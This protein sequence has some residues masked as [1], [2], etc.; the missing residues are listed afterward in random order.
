MGICLSNQQTQDTRIAQPSPAGAILPPEKAPTNL[1]DAP[2]QQQPPQHVNDSQQPIDSHSKLDPVFTRVPDAPEPGEWQGET[3]DVYEEDPLDLKPGQMFTDQ[4]RVLAL[5]GHGDIGS[6][7]EVESVT[8]DNV[9]CTIKM[10]RFWGREHL[11]EG[12]KAIQS[13]VS[14]L[15]HDNVLSVYDVMEN[16][17]HSTLVTIAA[18]ASRGNLFKY[19]GTLN[20][21]PEL[22]RKIALDIASGLRVLHSYGIYHGSL[23]LEDILET[24]PHVFAISDAGYSQLYD[25][26][27]LETLIE[28]DR[29]PLIPPEVFTATDRSMIDKGKMDVWG[30]GILLYQ[31]AFCMNPM[32][33]VGPVEEVRELMMRAAIPL[34]QNSYVPQDFLEVIQRCLEK[35]PTVRPNIQGVLRLNYFRNSNSSTTSLYGKNA[36]HARSFGSM[37]NIPKQSSGNAGHPE[38]FVVD[39]VIGKG[40]HGESFL[41]HLPSST[42]T[43]AFKALTHTLSYR[44]QKYNAEAD[45]PD[46]RRQ[47]AVGRK[48]RM[49]RHANVAG[50]LEFVDSHVS[51]VTQLYHG[52]GNVAMNFPSYDAVHIA[53]IMINDILKGLQVLHENRTYHCNL[54]PSNVFYG[55]EG[56]FVIT[57]FGPILNLPQEI[58]DHPSGCIFDVPPAT[59][60]LLRKEGTMEERLVGLRA[61]DT[62]SVGLMAASVIPLLRNVVFDQFTRS[63][64]TPL[65]ISYIMS[66]MNDYASSLQSGYIDLVAKALSGTAT[67]EELL[68]SE[69]LQNEVIAPSEAAV[70]LEIT[71]KDLKTAIKQRF[72]FAEERRLMTVAGRTTTSAHTPATSGIEPHRSNSCMS[73]GIQPITLSDDEEKVEFLYHDELTCCICGAIMKYVVYFAKANGTVRCGKCVD[74]PP[75]IEVQPMAVDIVHHF[76]N[77]VEGQSV[78]VL[79]PINLVDDHVIDELE[80]KADLKTGSLKPKIPQLSNREFSRAKLKSTK[81]SIFVRSV[82]V[83]AIVPPSDIPQAPVMGLDEQVVAP[84]AATEE[85]WSADDVIR[86]AAANR[87]TELALFSLKLTSVPQAIFAETFSTLITLDLSSNALTEIP[88]LGC[89]TCL[90]TL[91]LSRNKLSELSPSVGDLPSLVFLDVAHNNLTF[92]PQE[93][94]FCDNLEQIIAD[95]NDFTDIPECI[96]D[97]PSIQNVLLAEN[98]R[99]DR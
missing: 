99:I 71:E 2:K 90:K 7:Y 33:G 76:V 44:I 77:F 27:S 98:K 66:T 22:L 26:C 59:L 73:E 84:Q 56:T 72:E 68:K 81:S 29:L 53:I 62:F 13:K 85:D 47:I 48:T 65:D 96:F 74:V 17:E 54:K 24:R 88:D 16:H 91:R 49:N 87:S 6:T 95:Y 75:I 78:A 86:S 14:R 20:Q 1:S 15:Q 40:V 69:V 34:P 80:I 89:F 41:V 67:V 93:I 43:I 82:V 51:S 36:S 94:M 92:L 38:S 64:N 79:L 28:M 50:Y 32:R 30:F 18:F 45:L 8:A 39:S 35:D 97:M 3:E 58:V 57:D 12:V 63:S 60:K 23:K 83:P 11:I 31:L 37:S 19:I 55:D 25:D 61:I 46:I 52:K 4:Y 70:E 21:D 10:V 5:L 9:H 42:Y